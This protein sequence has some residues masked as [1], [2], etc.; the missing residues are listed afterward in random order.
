MKDRSS[1]PSCS[2]SE[3]FRK[4]F[5]FRKFMTLVAMETNPS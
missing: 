3:T 2:V 1:S 4:K 5:R